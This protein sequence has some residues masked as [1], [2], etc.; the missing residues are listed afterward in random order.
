MKKHERNLDAYCQVKEA[1]LEDA[2]YDSN[3]VT[4]WNR[5]KYGD[6]KK[7]GSIPGIRVK[8]R[9]NMQSKGNFQGSE[10]TLYDTTEVDI[11]HYI[12]VQ[13]HTTLDAKNKP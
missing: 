2:M 7:I 9:T 8:E 12:F 11:C 1:H 10:T 3:S 6:G 13:T 5:Q 4:Q